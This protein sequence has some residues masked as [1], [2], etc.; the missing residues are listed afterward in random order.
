MF[1]NYFKV[2]IRNL[3]GNKV[4]SLVNIA[5]LA[6]GMA[7]AILLLL[8]IQHILSMDQ[9]HTR[10]DQLYKVY[11]K[12]AI[13]GQVQCWATTPSP[14]GPALKR[15]YPEIKEY[16]RIEQ[17]EKLLRHGEQLLRAR[18]F[19]TDAAFLQLFSF[20][21]VIGRAEYA[22]DDPHR[23]VITEQLAKRLFG[24]EQPVGKIILVD[25]STNFTVSGVLKDL[26]NNTNFKFDYLIPW[27]YLS[28][29]GTENDSWKFAS[30]TTYVALQSG[31]NS[32]ALNK[33]VANLTTRYSEDQPALTNFL[34][35]LSRDFLYNRFENGLPSG[36]R[37]D[38][39]RMLG[40]LAGIILLIACINFMNLSTARSE[41]RA[42]EVGLRKVVG[43]RKRFLIL[44]FTG[45]SVLVAFIA[46][47]LA[48]CITQLLLPGFSELANVRMRIAW[49]SPLFWLAA[50]GFVL[51]TGILAGSYPAFYLSSFQPVKV[52]KGMFN[53]KKAF[54]TPRKILVVVQFVLSIF[55]INFTF[56]FRK[57]INHAQDR[58]IGY[59]KEQLIYHQLT[60]DIRTNYTV[61]QQELLDK[62]IA[63]AVGKSSMPVSLAGGSSV[64]GLNWEGKDPS[65]NVSFV[66]VNTRQDF[67]RI[68][69][70]TLSAGRDLNVQSFPMDTAGCLI[71][72]AAAKIMGL[73]D[74][75]GKLI[76]DA[77][78]NWTIVGV[79]KDFVIGSPNEVI[80]PLL[81]LG[82]SH[83]SFINIRL[84][85]NRA[86]M[87]NLKAAQAIL[88]KYNPGFLTEPG[89]AD[90]DY[91]KKFKEAV[92]VGVL[93]NNFAFIAI[94]I[95]CMGLFGLV[96]YM[97]ETRNRE[98]SIRK[99][100]GASIG[101]VMALLV[102]DFVKLVVLAIVI[103]SPI[104]WLAMNYFLQQFPYRT[105][106]SI[107]I[108][109]ISGIG[110][111]LIALLTIGW[112][113]IKAA[114]ANPIRS[115]RVQ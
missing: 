43:A 46:G 79:V 25:N 82:S 44:Q 80:K 50:I 108:P 97:A 18:G 85:P 22:L 4:L 13:N 19:V 65:L 11:N 49:E 110:A 95:S 40:F 106:N 73:K 5:G 70:L 57:Q 74:P 30:V 53:N 55:L 45:E 23:I 60:D 56:I 72:E 41:K 88:A 54:V 96:T 67:A 3:L 115:L 34:Y 92:N 77:G 48:L 78:Y 58:E 94:F 1:K 47:V 102:V 20:P 31:A 75:V 69:G 21:L 26:P 112:Q 62:G 32:E 84:N 8:N 107:W 76:L 38:N 64:S 101:E 89:Y 104:A 90:E 10:K 14:L 51:L 27:Q 68:N 29:S 17:G 52:L 16:T 59:V 71:N 86:P 37:I 113:S 9:F 81:V 33:K 83:A 111:L 109:V 61:I 35:P 6:M 42:K 15:D 93:F 103:A 2:A 36:G 28:K 99:V 87:E 100:L 24:N 12:E 91:A 114:M 105:T 66:L 39:L 7:G 63:V 98:I